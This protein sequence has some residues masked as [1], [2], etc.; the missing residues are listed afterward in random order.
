MSGLIWIQTVWHSDGMSERIF[1]KVDFENISKW[2][3]S[4]KNYP[5]SKDL[6]VPWPATESGYE[7][8]FWSQPSFSFVYV[9]SEGS[10]KTMDAQACLSLY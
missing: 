5:V 10:G 7:S 6:N 9:S 8:N 4:M 3:N 1:Q 2:Q